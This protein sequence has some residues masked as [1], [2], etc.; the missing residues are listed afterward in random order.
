MLNPS[1]Q[2][3]LT[4]VL[5]EVEKHL[6]GIEAAAQPGDTISVAECSELRRFVTDM[7]T[8]IAKLT[9]KFVQL[10]VPESVTPR[11]QV[12]TRL[13]FALVEFLELTSKKLRGYGTL[14]DASF[15]QLMAQ[16][17]PMQSSLE[18]LIK[19]Y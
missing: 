16:I 13:E 10:P 3:Y 15:T 18:A 14:D 12:H 19:K 2:R 17:A 11:W 5:A 6:T 9:Q 8:Q 4:A 7:R 1:Q